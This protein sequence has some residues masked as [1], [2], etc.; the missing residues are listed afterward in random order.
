MTTV[1][2]LLRAAV[3]VDRSSLQLT[4]GLR[5]AA[6]VGAPLL[7]GVAVDRLIEGVAV[8]TG[9]LL[10]G[11][12]DSG[13]PYRRR[14]PAML[15]A[16]LV[17]ARAT[18]VGEL[19]G[20]HDA[21]TVVILA[22]ASFV[23]G[24]CI[25][26]GL[27]A[28]LVALM[29][30]VTFV[31]AASV[32]TD[33]P[34]A[35]GR[36]A[37]VFAGGFLEVALVLV[38]WRVD[39]EL[40]ER[41]AVARLY[42]SVAEWLG[43]GRTVDDRAPVF[44]AVAHARDVLD[45]DATG[46]RP[47]PALTGLGNRIFGELA[48]LR[49][50][51]GWWDESDIDERR[52]A[53][54]RGPAEASSGRGAV[55]AALN[56]VADRIARP[57]ARSVSI[58]LTPGDHGSVATARRLRGVIADVDQAWGLA[59]DLPAR[60]PRSARGSSTLSHV[61]PRHGL[62]VAVTAVPSATRRLLGVLGANL[63]LRSSACRHA[64]RLAVA[65]ALASGVARALQL[66][67]D[68]WVPLTALWL[69]RP[70][71]GSTFTRGV[72][73]YAG[74][75]A[76]AVLA[77]LFAATVHPGP[78]ALSILA[79]A[80]SVGIF[81]FM[82]ANY[83]VTGACTTGWVVFVSALAGIPELRAAADRVLDASLGAVIALGSYLLWPTWERGEVSDTVADV[84]DAARRY[85]AVVLGCWLDPD[86]ADRDAIER[87]RTNARATRT[88]TEATLARSIAEPANSP[89][90]LDPDIATRLLAAMRRFC[91]GPLALEQSRGTATAHAAS[92]ASQA[93]VTALDSAMR[94]LADAARANR[95]LESMVAFERLRAARASAQRGLDPDDPLQLQANVMVAAVDD[96]VAALRP[97][98]DRPA[99]GSAQPAAPV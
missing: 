62:A 98:A 39:P 51:R 32:P 20:A 74:T 31:G 2:R 93:L 66:P 59:S 42:R 91:D 73:R 70:D 94:A 54:V 79:T 35:L 77:T 4:R 47:L 81:C 25:S 11:L 82:L 86:Q 90:G 46:D 36:A 1:A 63:T 43:H 8:S 92:P 88:N 49:S 95:A 99:P 48:L 97:L 45:D 9:A 3:R 75:T 38:A 80:L 22:L 34:H 85:A 57:G 15:V 41:V 23:T 61:A 78:Y 72:Q 64:I 26:A 58:S 65:A 18:F 7:V 33:G 44:L 84:I 71:F 40:P 14:V 37:L 13:A 27:W 50:D 6:G 83:G 24:L 60:V 56:A 21:L 19:V 29:G 53:R 76:G 16:S 68:Y 89:A 30:P 12:T 52:S 28:Y 69:L 10:V 55:V 17:V 87:S 67:H 5:Y 96:A